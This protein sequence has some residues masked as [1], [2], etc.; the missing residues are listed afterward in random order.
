MSKLIQIIEQTLEGM[1]FALVDIDQQHQLQILV[2]AKDNPKQHPTLGECAQIS[3]Q[4][5]R[6]LEV[7][8][9]EYQRLEVSSPGIDRP[10]RNWQDFVAFTGSVIDL[11]LTQAN[12]YGQKK[13][14]EVALL[15]TTSAQEL[16]IS[17]ERSE[18]G[19]LTLPF[20]LIHKAKIS[21][22][23]FFKKPEVKRQIRKKK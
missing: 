5:S 10:L 20:A 6:V 8:G 18:T 9:L 23:P 3:Q 4:L 12:E 17:Y 11:Q 7:E 22:A 15:S 16:I 19:Q 13:F 2:C 1:G 21:L 14:T